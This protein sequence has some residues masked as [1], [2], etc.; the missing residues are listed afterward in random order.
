MSLR[1][2]EATPWMW[3]IFAAIF[4]SNIFCPESHNSYFVL[5]YP[6]FK[7]K[8]C[9]DVTNAMGEDEKS[10]CEFNGHVVC[11]PPNNNLGQYNLVC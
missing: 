11:E 5:N 4:P 8:Q 7:V 9:L 1:P 3:I 6:T 2:Y 10:L